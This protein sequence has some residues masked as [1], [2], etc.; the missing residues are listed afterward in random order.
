MLCLMSIK[1]YYDYALIS[2]KY[3][4]V[5]TFEFNKA[6]EPVQSHTRPMFEDVASISP[7]HS[8]VNFDCQPLSKR[9]YP[10]AA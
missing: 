6:N 9:G 7:S 4:R 3:K 10:L 5:Q 1:I 2:E 8:W